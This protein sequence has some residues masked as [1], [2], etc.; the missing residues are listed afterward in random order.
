MYI[1][2]L[3]IIF[4]GDLLRAEV[5]SGSDLGQEMNNIMKSGGLVPDEV[6]LEIIK[7]KM[8]NS[9]SSSNRFLLD[10]YPRKVDQALKFER[11]VSHFDMLFFFYF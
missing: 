4:P 3:Y 7:S 10:G 6:I 8:A 5:E 2:L 1:S 9:L 11:L